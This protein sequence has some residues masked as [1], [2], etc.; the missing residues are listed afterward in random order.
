VL[1]YTTEDSRKWQAIPTVFSPFSFLQVVRGKAPIRK[2]RWVRVKMSNLGQVCA[3]CA[4]MCA[5][6]LS[7]SQF[8]C[9]LGTRWSLA[10]DLAPGGYDHWRTHIDADFSI[11]WNCNGEARQFPLSNGR[12]FT[13]LGYIATVHWFLRSEAADDCEGR[14]KS[15]DEG[16]NWKSC[17]D[18]YVYDWFV[19]YLQITVCWCFLL[20]I[21]LCN[22]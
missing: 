14:L 8:Y 20:I 10:T 2:P 22:N 18:S 21:I 17:P 1:T 3:V 19:F 6:T 7:S 4:N 5:I 12:D 11:L 9:C 15:M 13:L 16:G